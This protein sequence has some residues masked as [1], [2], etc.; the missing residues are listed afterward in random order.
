MNIFW[1]RQDLR[2][3]DNPGLMH[4][5][6]T[7]DFKNVLP[8]Y[9]LDDTQSATFGHLGGASKWWLHQ[10]LTSLNKDIQGKLNFY[11]GNPLD[12]LKEL[13]QRFA[14]QKVIWNR[15]Y[16]PFIIERDSIIKEE[17]K[18][19]GIECKSFNAS[20]LWEPHTILK[21]DQTPYQVFTPYYQ[22][23]CLQAEPPRKQLP[24][25]PSAL[26]YVTDND[27]QTTLNDFTLIPN[28]P[29]YKEM[30]VFW[31]VGENAAQTKL[32]TFLENGLQGY[33][34]ER[35]FPFKASVSMLSP[36]L[37][38]GEISP[39]QIWHAVKSYEAFASINSA[40]VNSFLSELGWR[41]FSYY[42]LYHY[43]QM[44]TQNLKEKFNHF[45][46]ATNP[47]HL[48]AFQK[49]MTGCPIVDA[50]MR[51]LWQTGYM[52]GR[53]RMIVGSF[54]VKNLRISWQEGAAW[55]WDCLVDADLASNSASWQWVAGSGFDAAPYFRI[56][57]PILQA[58]KFDP[59][60]SYIKTYV[61]ELKKLEMPYL[62]APWT[63]PKEV[64]AKA[65]VYLGTSYPHLIIDLDKSRKAALEAFEQIKGS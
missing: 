64:L 48:K 51:Q 21:S 60:G 28:I 47:E 37:H 27:N 40:D 46:W 17:L 63:A 11:K 31:Q 22:K 38:F 59:D 45:P 23:G 12:I 53:A 57:N 34:E 20:L 50:G 4:A 3:N 13:S 44:P 29:W 18:K 24:P 8:I 16:E 2:L 15:C 39:H 30:E 52:H 56:F 62:A 43:P 61:P 54:L 55:F 9:I 1:F 7:C 19:I 65:G 42:Q 36:H 25:L 26:T 5:L 58:Q 14:I 32:K 41:E 49:G 10:S 33:K 35:N 6:E